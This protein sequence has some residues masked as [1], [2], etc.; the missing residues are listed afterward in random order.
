MDEPRD[1]PNSLVANCT[2]NTT[3][4]RT[5][6]NCEGQCQHVAH[7]FLGPAAA[8]GFHVRHAVSR[9]QSHTIL[10]EYTA[11]CSEHTITLDQY[12]SC[13]TV[14]FNPVL[15][16]HGKTAVLCC[17]VLCH[18]VHAT[19]QRPCILKSFECHTVHLADH[20]FVMCIPELHYLL[21]IHLHKRLL[22]I[23]CGYANKGGNLGVC[24]A[25]HVGDS[26]I[27]NGP[28]DVTTSW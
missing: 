10:W 26:N 16:S 3:K 14:S 19:H 7:R 11:V 17:A 1:R 23:N 6:T 25:V 21:L 22:H 28:L 18:A 20:I 13:R 27:S 2:D 12:M 4:Q 15:C 9:A 5:K 8:A 24:C